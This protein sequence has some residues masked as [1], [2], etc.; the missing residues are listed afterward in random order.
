MQV[1]VR[2]VLCPRQRPA[3]FG[4]IGHEGRAEWNLTWVKRNL[5]VDMR[6]V[7]LGAG[8]LAKRRVKS[9]PASA[10]RQTGPRLQEALGTVE[11]LVNNAG[12]GSSADPRPVAE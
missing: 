11:I 1:G 5:T 7:S 6:L 3:V 10:Q 2:G 8:C 12:V 4:G 9:K